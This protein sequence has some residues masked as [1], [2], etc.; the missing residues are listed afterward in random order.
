M[1]YR[2]LPMRL[3]RWTARSLLVPALLAAAA[4]LYSLPGLVA[5]WRFGSNYD[6]AIFDQA[7][8]HLSRFE[9]PASTIHGLNVLGD[10]FSPILALAAPLYWLAP[11]PETLIVL[12]GCL[13]AASLLPVLAFLRRRLDE[14]HAV[15]LCI[16]YLLFWGLQRAAAFDF[17]ELAFAPLFIALAVLAA[18]TRRYRLLWFASA[19]LVLVKE[20]L[21][22]FLAVLGIFVAARGDR[23]HGVALTAASLAAFAVIVGLVVPAFNEGGVYRYGGTF[24][25]VLAR[26][27]MLPLTLMTPGIKALT[28]LMWLAPF[29]FLPL[30]SP[31]ALLAVPIAV[32]RLLS[33]NPL[34]WGPS[35]HYSAPLAPILAMAAGDGLA[36]LARLVRDERHRRRL[37][38]ALTGVAIVFSLVLPGRQPVFRLFRAGEFQ[39]SPVLASGRRALATVP[40]GVSVVAQT[41][42][43]PHLSH[44]D[45]IYRLDE[46]A[47]EAEFL[48]AALPLSPWPLPDRAAVQGMI[49]ARRSRG[50]VVVFE[51]NGWIVLRRAPEK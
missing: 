4:C 23:R 34:H 20:D 26:P 45:A 42:I 50:Y 7:V 22:P 37:L 25:E 8:W 3:E 28:V 21:L 44:R 5:H 36:R 33:A 51:E 13:F 1:C 14:K 40:A 29:A 12:Q 10:H 24:R 18:D 17:H 16:A 43:A 27:W 11:A 6:L 30:A 46:Q 35:F 2:P 9:A 49:D 31:I 48:I 19:A 15:A 47:P 41:A 32:T 38:H 39:E